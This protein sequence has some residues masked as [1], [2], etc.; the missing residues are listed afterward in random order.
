[1]GVLVDKSTTN[2]INGL[3][4]DLV[5]IEACSTEPNPT[6]ERINDILFCAG[7]RLEQPDG[8]IELGGP[9]QID[10]QSTENKIKQTIHSGELAKPYQEAVLGI[11]GGA[12]GGVMVGALTAARRHKKRH[13]TRDE[14]VRYVR[15]P[16]QGANFYD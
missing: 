3:K 5:T 4:R 13:A 1:M 14:Q 7:V 6:I 15:P 9:V 8:K 11:M 12:L 2:E 16:K 10:W